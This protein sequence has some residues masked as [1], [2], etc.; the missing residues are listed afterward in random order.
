MPRELDDLY[1]EIIERIR[2]QPEDDGELGMRVLSWVTHTRRP[3][4]VDELRHGLAV[5]YD[6]DEEASHKLDTDNLLSSGSLVDVCAGLVVIDPGSQII[7]LVHYTTQEYFDKNRRQLFEG[8]E[9]DISRACLTYL[10]YDFAAEMPN[11]VKI[12]DVMLTHFFLGYASLFWISHVEASGEGIGA[13]QVLT[14]AIAY[15]QDSDK[16]LFSS[17]V[18]RKLLLRPRSYA[19]VTEEDLR[20]RKS[21]LPLETAAESGLD[22]H[23]EF[24][25]KHAIPA[26]AA[27]DSALNCAAAEGHFSIAK[28]L[29]E[30]GAQVESLTVDSSNALQKAC[31]GGHLE[32]AKVLLETGANPNTFDRWRLT[33]LHHAAHGGHSALAALLINKG[34][35]VH[36]QTPLGLTA[37]H[38][39]VSRGDLETTILLLDAGFDLKS[40][41]RGRRTV[42]HS[43]AEAEHVGV[44]RLLLQRGANV[45]AKNDYGE[46]AGNLVRD[47]ASTELRGVFAAYE[48]VSF[49]QPTA[50]SDNTS[51]AE[52]RSCASDT[53]D[54]DTS[55]IGLSEE[56][57]V[58]EDRQ[59]PGAH[60][61]F[62]QQRHE[63]ERT[64]SSEEGVKCP[65]EHD[66]EVKEPQD[67]R[68]RRERTQ[69]NRESEH[70]DYKAAEKED[71]SSGEDIW[72]PKSGRQEGSE[73]P[74]TAVHEQDSETSLEANI[75]SAPTQLVTISTSFEPEALS[76]GTAPRLMLIEPTPPSSPLSLPSSPP[77]SND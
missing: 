74:N 55:S 37:C 68:E 51:F 50:R 21:M 64:N 20:K 49:E 13:C 11:N 46:T 3:L 59:K 75:D 25:L 18:L 12:S 30:C 4:S 48:K 5:E 47:N 60:R 73:G 32:V 19:R 43:A 53:S 76:L 72:R 17:M 34:S 61:K 36:N 8:A 65:H 27:L 14:P 42:L 31:K 44:V 70:E 58:Y 9:V 24:L 66:D 1:G 77:S 38:L 22:G 62:E 28:K 40:T 54:S 56:H 35:N 23:A 63:C 26:Q 16:L 71:G 33:P 69:Q 45:S 39:A 10:C 2:R 67:R 57:Q 41:S 29:I 52:L 7:R 6:D 15:I